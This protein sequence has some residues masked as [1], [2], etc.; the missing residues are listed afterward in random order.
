[1]KMKKGRS[2]RP[3]GVRAFEMAAKTTDIKAQRETSAS[4]RHR[5]NEEF[6]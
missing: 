4:L 2:R 1:M 5:R 6:G 3:S